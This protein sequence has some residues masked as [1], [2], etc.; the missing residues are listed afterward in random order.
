MATDYIQKEILVVT[1][2]RTREGQR[3]NLDPESGGSKDNVKESFD[4][5]CWNGFLDEMLPLVIHRTSRNS[6]LFIWDLYI[7]QQTVC[8][9]IAEGPLSYDAFHSINPYVFL[10]YCHYC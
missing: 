4:E 3:L 6:P 10:A 9:E 2:S 5:A 7:G 1:T 8:A